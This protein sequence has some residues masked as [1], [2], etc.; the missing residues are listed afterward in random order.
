L[1]LIGGKSEIAS[2]KDILPNKCVAVGRNTLFN[3][4]FQ[5]K[6]I[7]LN[8]FCGFQVVPLVKDLAP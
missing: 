2:I 5:A 3:S 7:V 1:V 4:F 6:I 8:R